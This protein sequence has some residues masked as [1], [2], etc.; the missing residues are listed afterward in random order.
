MSH[1]RFAPAKAQKASRAK[2]TKEVH[3]MGP[4]GPIF[5]HALASKSC[6]PP[7][8]VQAYVPTE[9]PLPLV[10]NPDDAAPS[11]GFADETTYSRHSNRKHRQAHTWD[12]EILPKLIRCF[13]AYKRAKGSPLP[14]NVDTV[15]CTMAGCTGRNISVIVVHMEC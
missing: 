7:R 13:M 11:N 8:T 14:E 2:F 9:I 5:S 4:D 6:L 3:G 10:Y 1:R 12:T 15:S